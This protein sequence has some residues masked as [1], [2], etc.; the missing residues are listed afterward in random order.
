M[1]C[2]MNLRAAVSCKNSIGMLRLSKEWDEHGIASAV[3]AR[4]TPCHSRRFIPTFFSYLSPS[5]R[6]VN[7]LEI[8]TTNG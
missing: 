7:E 5:L 6:E 4:F 8:L 3:R 2:F 1:D